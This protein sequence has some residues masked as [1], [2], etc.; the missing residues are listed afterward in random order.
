[1]SEISNS[2]IFS[3]LR[4]RTA[5]GAPGPLDKGVRIMGRSW[6][7]RVHAGL[8]AL[9]VATAV[10]LV[11]PAEAAWAV[12]TDP[13]AAAETAGV[14]EERSAAE[15]A[16][17]ATDPRSGTAV[18]P[19]RSPRQQAREQ[20]AAA[21]RARE[22]AAAQRASEQARARKRAIQL[23]AAGQRAQASWASHGRPHKMIIIRQRSVDLVQSGRLFRQV[24]RSGAAVTLSTLDRLVPEDW[25]RVNSGT[26]DLTA[27]IVLGPAQILT[28]G[29]DVRTVRLAGGPTPA[30]A[31]S[32]YTGSGRL[33]L[34]EVAV[35][36]YDAATAQPLPVGPGRPFIV[37]NGGGRIESVDST[38]SDLGT[39]PTDPV[40]RA[41]LALGENSSGSLL[42][43]QLVRNGIGLK[44]D[45]TDAVRL[46]GVTV[47]D[48]A[49][50]GVVLRGDRGTALVGLTATG[51]G[52]NGVLV[53]GPSSDR[54]ITGVSASGNKGFGI[55]LA[56]QT[57]PRVDHVT[58]AGN[59]VGGVRVSQSSD[60]TISD[61]TSTDEAIG[62][63]THVGS[64]R[65][66]IDRAQIIRARRGLHVEK[67]TKELTLNGSTIVGAS[68]A[69]V[70][71]GG[72]QTTLNQVAI[73]DSAA[74]MRVERG[75][76]EVTV[77]GLNLTG[78]TDGVVALSATKNV[79]LRNVVADGVARTAI[80]TFSANLQVLDSRITGSATGIDAGAATT[81]TGT[82]IDDVE[83]G[84]RSRS[85][86]LVDVNDATV[87]ALSVGINVAPGSPVRLA[88][89]QVD[90]L[91]AIRGTLNQDGLNKLSLPPLNLLGAIGVPLILVALVLEQVQ[92][93]RAR[94]IGH[95]ARR[96]PPS[97]PAE[98]V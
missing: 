89:S 87:S 71:I 46:E 18:D 33:T 21:Q 65:V 77:N 6:R 7:G 34:R 12:G 54:P 83:E 30:D 15:P 95:R 80:R 82:I 5:S 50:D 81:I 19:T 44:L 36:S 88:G 41:G 39:V 10:L 42:R 4:D 31:A 45:R 70:S 8:A 96:L 48:S 93:Y 16:E 53:T 90:A 3:A 58:T 1:L 94:G 61:I 76:G 75:A 29:G 22:Q 13:G 57:H 97:L 78:G 38:I 98:T 9:V 55:A 67:T 11:S 91:E 84:I 59:T 20:A 68:I 26:A 28:L 62:I 35:A 73:T 47:S 14:D 17:S 64:E 79:V 23:A 25:L 63:Y 85:S 60:V 40:P 66:T 86:A 92:A 37:I 49:G 27:T 24:P 52:G 32:I 51:N 74:A 69:G 72:H 43:T 2:L 56:G